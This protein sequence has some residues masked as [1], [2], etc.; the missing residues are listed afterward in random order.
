MSEY[1]ARVSI[2]RYIARLTTGVSLAAVRQNLRSLLTDDTVLGRVGGALA[3]IGILPEVE[4]A[5]GTAITPRIVT[6][7]RLKAVIESR[8]LTYLLARTGSGDG[9]YLSQTSGALTWAASTAYTD[10]Q[11]VDAIEAVGNG[12]LVTASGVLDN[13]VGATTNHALLWTGST[14]AAGAVPYSALSGV[15]STFA[16]SSHTHTASEITDFNT[17]WTARLTALGSGASI[18]DTLEWDGSAFVAATPSGGGMTNPMTTAWDLIRGGASGTPT[19][20]AVGSTFFDVLATKADGTFAWCPQVAGFGRMPARYSLAIADGNGTPVMFGWTTAVTRVQTSSGNGVRV[21]RT[22]GGA[23]HRQST[24]TAANQWAGWAL[25]TSV[26]STIAPYGS[27]IAILRGDESSGSAYAYGLIVGTTALNGSTGPYFNAAPTT[28]A[29]YGLRWRPATQTTWH[30]IM[31]DGS[32]FTETDTGVTVTGNSSGT[33]TDGTTHGLVVGR[34][35]SGVWWEIW[36]ELTSP[37]TLLGSGRTNAN[38]PTT[39]ANILAV[40]SGFGSNGASANGQTNMLGFTTLTVGG[41]F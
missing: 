25:A 32:T 39:F 28:F 18:G 37:P 38:V 2:A 36:N 3:A 20:L 21:S 14:W 24:S 6:A 34:D 9:K 7:A 29:C 10:E 11:A 41:P 27:S 33:A 35:P 40:Y 26:S 5:T 8:I 13:V 17:A 1:V 12:V 15:P 19:R 4:A 31:Y 16:P 30:L 23:L 22:G